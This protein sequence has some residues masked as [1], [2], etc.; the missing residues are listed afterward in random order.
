MAELRAWENQKLWSGGPRNKSKTAA[1]VC[2]QSL[3]SAFYRNLCTV[4]SC[5]STLTSV[6]GRIVIP[7]RVF[8]TCS[9]IAFGR[10]FGVGFMLIGGLRRRGF[11]EESFLFTD[12]RRRWNVHSLRLTA[13]GFLDRRISG[14]VIGCVAGRL[15]LWYQRVRY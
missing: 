9:V 14:L 8:I 6:L 13:F 15:C 2:F 10:M 7:G 5:L 1:M 4:S 12:N 3:P 11:T